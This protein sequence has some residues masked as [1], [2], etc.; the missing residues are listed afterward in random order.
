MATLKYYGLAT[1]VYSYDGRKKLAKIKL[2]EDGKLARKK[3]QSQAHA[4]NQLL[5]PVEVD[6]ANEGKVTSDQIFQLVDRFK[7]QNPQ[8]E[9]GFTFDLKI[10]N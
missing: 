4:T 7:K 3:I 9:V 10:K 6:T 5:I 2:T 1:P 8:Y